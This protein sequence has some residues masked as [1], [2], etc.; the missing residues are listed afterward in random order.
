MHSRVPG[1]RHFPALSL[2]TP[3]PGSLRGGAAWARWPSRSSKPVRCGNP[4]LGRFDS[5][6]A[7]SSRLPF[8]QRA[9]GFGDRSG[10]AGRKAAGDRWRPPETESDCGKN[11]ASGRVSWLPPAVSFGSSSRPD[12]RTTP[13]PPS[14][15]P[16]PNEWEQ[17]E[18]WRTP[19]RTSRR[20]DSHDHTRGSPPFN[21]P[22]TSPHPR[23][24]KRPRRPRHQAPRPT[25]LPRGSPAPDA[26]EPRSSQRWSDLRERRLA[27][28]GVALRAARTKGLAGAV[29]VGVSFGAVLS[30]PRPLWRVLRVCWPALV[31]GRLARRRGAT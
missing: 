21:E 30:R 20:P 29:Q 27:Q 19:Y 2:P 11:V 26:A 22:T 10:H 4:T 23:R 16:P 6:A 8:P 17:Q 9:R 31:R 15:P 1:W 13:T 24:A 28:S 12:H 14:A 18:R 3:L 5:G 25:S 7:P